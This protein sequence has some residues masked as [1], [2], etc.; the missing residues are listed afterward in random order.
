MVDQQRKHLHLRVS[1]A[2]LRVVDAWRREQPDLPSRS[3][4]VRRLV[5]ECANTEE[6][7]R[8]HERTG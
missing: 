1:A 5:T 8:Q 2:F 3:E 7:K 4:A 6:Q